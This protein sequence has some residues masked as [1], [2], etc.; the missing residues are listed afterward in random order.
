MH[1]KTYARALGVL[2]LALALAPHTARALPLI[3][4]VFYD[5]AG[6]DNG[7]SF[8]EIYGAPGTIL[9]GYVIEGINGANGAVTPSVVL[10]GSIPEDGLFLVADDA[11]DGT[12]LVSAADLIANFDFQNG[13]DSV[14]L[15]SGGDVIDAVG[16]GDFD[17]GEFFAGEGA[18]APDAPPGSSIARRFADVD[19][20]DNAADWIAAAPTP[21][22]APLSEVPEPDTGVLLAAGF[23]ALAHRARR[24]RS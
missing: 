13:P 19:S 6:S 24:S 12:T 10:I 22:S 11:G 15:R 7:L 2:I 14:V 8:V 21:G 23:V 20:D 4:E 18:P 1:R 5:A 16:Y 9:D 3:S 17:P